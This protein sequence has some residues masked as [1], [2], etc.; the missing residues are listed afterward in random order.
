MRFRL[1][2]IVF[3]G[4]SVLML[5]TCLVSFI[6]AFSLINKPFAGFFIY[7]FPRVG[8]MSSVDWPGVRAGLKTMERIVSADAQP[9]RI[10]R[11]VLEI[12]RGRPLGTPIHYTVE[13][14]KEIRSIVVPTAKFSIRDFFIVFLIPFTGGVILLCLGFIAYVLKPNVSTSWVF[15]FLSLCLAV[16]MVTG[17]EMQSTYFFVRLHYIVIPLMPATLFHMGLIFPDRKRVIARYP[18][19][20]YVVYLPTLILI[21]GY[22]IYLFTFS[23]ERFTS[24]V[25]GICTITNVNRAFSFACVAGLIML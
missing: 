10:G 4:L 3:Y 9:V 21:L 8:S 19:L 5:V 1:P 23:S 13:S 14:G 16:Y 6:N 22:Q 2:S 20:E 7:K 15:F 25:P 18:L 24:W 12:S 17:V 11:D